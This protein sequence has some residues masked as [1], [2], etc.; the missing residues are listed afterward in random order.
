MKNF[1]R[2]LWV[3]IIGNIIINIVIGPWSSEMGTHQS[4]YHWVLLLYVISILIS[5]FFVWIYLFY[6]WGT[7]QFDSLQAKRR[8]F[9]VLLIGGF[10]YLIGPFIYYL[11]IYEKK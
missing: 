6:H 3:F 5:A 9:F 2:F 7:V 8:W 10:F 11:R 1:L 4:P